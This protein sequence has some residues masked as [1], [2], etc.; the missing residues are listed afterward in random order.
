MMTLL[1]ILEIKEFIFVDILTNFKY[2]ICQIYTLIFVSCTRDITK[3]RSV[4]V[5]DIREALNKV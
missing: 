2:D 4:S 3:L 1:W 5:T